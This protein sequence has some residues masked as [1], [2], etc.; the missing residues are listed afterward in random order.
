M[1]GITTCKERKRKKDYR[2]RIRDTHYTQREKY[3]KGKGNNGKGIIYRHAIRRIF[4]M[5]KCG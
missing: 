3:D 1:S 2:E 5:E 4:L